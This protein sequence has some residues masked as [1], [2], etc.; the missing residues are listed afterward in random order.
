MTSVIIIIKLQVPC[1]PSR[2]LYTSLLHHKAARNNYV[3]L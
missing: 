2:L 1:Y 3:E